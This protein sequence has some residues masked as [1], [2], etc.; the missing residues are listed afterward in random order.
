MAHGT[1]AIRGLF[2]A[3]RDDLGDLLRRDARRRARPVVVGEHLDDQSFEV[4]SGRPLGLRRRQA[5]LSLGPSAP[6][7]PNALVVDTDLIGLFAVQPVLGAHQDDLGPLDKALRLRPRTGEA[8]QDRPLLLGEL[9]DALRPRH[10]HLRLASESDPRESARE[11][12]R[13]LCPG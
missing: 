6:P 5:V 11:G 9:H 12:A 13:L 1:P 4:T 8:L 10:L 2:T 3:N 7:T